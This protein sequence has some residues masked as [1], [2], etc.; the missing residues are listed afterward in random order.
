MGLEPKRFSGLGDWICQL[1][2]VPKKRP[3]AAKAGALNE[4][5]THGYKWSLR[6][7]FFGDILVSASP[8]HL[9]QRTI[10]RNFD[11]TAL[12]VSNQP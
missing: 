11:N 3:V 6:A 1:P 10:W 2:W 8:D 7:S 5:I 4:G 12:T 9:R